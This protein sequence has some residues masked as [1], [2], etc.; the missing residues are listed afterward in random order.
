MLTPR[1]VSP[2]R[3]IHDLAIRLKHHHLPRHHHRPQK[4]F[5]PSPRERQVRPQAPPATP[6]PCRTGRWRGHRKRRRGLLRGDGRASRG[7]R[8]G[9]CCRYCGRH[10]IPFVGLIQSGETAVEAEWTSIHHS[11]TPVMPSR[12]G[13]QLPL[14]TNSTDW[15][16]TAG[17]SSGA[18]HSIRY[19]LPRRSSPL[20][21]VSATV[22]RV[23]SSLRKR[24]TGS[25]H[26]SHQVLAGHPQNFAPPVRVAED[27]A[28]RLRLPLRRPA[29]RAGRRAYRPC[30]APE[31]PPC[32]ASFRDCTRCS[33]RPRRSLVAAG[34]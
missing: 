32:S 33:S 14:P 4:R 20:G 29:R 16:S 2:R 7:R 25:D 3:L 1:T 13:T 15:I 21:T 18:F 17:R 23:F 11:I 34:C 5:P 22:V 27:V 10:S 6:L 31:S 28:E 26:Q 8:G 19:T 24:C 12:M 30:G 9:A